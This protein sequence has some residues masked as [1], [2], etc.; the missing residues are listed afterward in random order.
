MINM[1]GTTTGV[2]SC[3]VARRYSVLILTRL[4]SGGEAQQLTK[5]SILIVQLTESL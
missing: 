4:R 2:T 5:V 3:L 1:R